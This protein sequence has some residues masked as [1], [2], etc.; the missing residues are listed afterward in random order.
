MPIV[1][2]A[3]HGHESAHYLA[4]GD[5]YTIGE[6]VD[7]DGRWPVQLAALLRKRGITIAHPQVIAR[8]GWTTAEL[9]AAIDEEQAQGQ[10]QPNYRLV[11]LLIGVNNEYRG[12]SVHDYAAD[13]ARLLDR[14][15]GFAGGHP[16]H[17]LVV[18]I[19]DWGSTP[20]A[21]GSG[22]DRS[23][24]SREIDQFNAVAATLCKQRGATWVN[25]TD[26]TRNPASANLLVADGL[27][28]SGQMYRL[29]V[30]R[31]LATLPM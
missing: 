18:S 30:D 1:D 11:S 25:I 4:L 28:P 5:S 3:T 21:L 13:F 19:P 14:A 2:A 22:R 6:G 10:L 16:G 29:W 9:S 7:D 26:I 31:I 24:I 23:R 12:A 17:V 27:H 15:I 8:T 20:F